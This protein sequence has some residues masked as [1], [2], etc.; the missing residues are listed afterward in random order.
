MAGGF[1]IEDD[2]VW[3]AEKKRDEMREVSGLVRR[4]SSWCIVSMT[5]G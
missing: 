1:C 4:L 5:P 2:I 3:Q